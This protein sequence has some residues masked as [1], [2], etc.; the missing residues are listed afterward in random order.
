MVDAFAIFI[1]WGLSQYICDRNYARGYFPIERAVYKYYFEIFRGT[2][3]YELIV[4]L[5]K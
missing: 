3:V 2:I 1:I 4:F 5:T